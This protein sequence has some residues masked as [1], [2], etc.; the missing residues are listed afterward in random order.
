MIAKLLVTEKN[1]LLWKRLLAFGIDVIIVLLIVLVVY[2]ISPWQIPV[3]LAKWVLFGVWMTFT[4]WFDYFRMGTPGKQI[5]RITIVYTY[6]H[7]SYLLS[8]LYRNF[9]RILFFTEFFWILVI[10]DRQGLHNQVAKCTIV[11]KTK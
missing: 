3:P 10:P 7:R 6:Q 2:M 5:T 11:E 1:R 8:V 9:L 4:M